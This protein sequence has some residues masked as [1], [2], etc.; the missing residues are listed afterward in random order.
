MATLA[1]D[2]G[3]KRVGVALNSY[4]DIVSELETIS[5]SDLENLLNQISS[6]VDEYG[7]TQIVLGKPRK[8]SDLEKLAQNITS[9]FNLKFAFVD[10][11]LSTKEAER[12]LAGEGTTGGD[13]DARSAKIILEQYLSEL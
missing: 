5:Y 12:Q 10:E 13:T 7:V 8:D 3:K 9:H 1:L 2:I 4:S 6:L 11:A